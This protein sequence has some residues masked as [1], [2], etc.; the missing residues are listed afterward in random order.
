MET[1]EQAKVIGLDNNI[2]MFTLR[3]RINGGMGTMEKKLS[4]LMI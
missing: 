3:L 2:K 4:Y 1:Q